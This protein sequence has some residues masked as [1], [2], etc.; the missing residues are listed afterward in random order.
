MTPCLF[1]SYF[2][3]LLF[4]FPLSSTGVVNPWHAC[5]NWHASTSIRHVSEASET[6]SSP[7]QMKKLITYKSQY[8]Q[9]KLGVRFFIFVC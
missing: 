7:L 1:H 2:F 5:R 8:Y 9:M 4:L 6:R 3:T